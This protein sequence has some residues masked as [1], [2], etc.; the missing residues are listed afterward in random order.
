[1]VS[2]ERIA[3]VVFLLDGQPQLS[4]T[5]PPYSAELRLAELPREQVVRVEGYDA[6]GE[7]VAWDQVVLNQ[8][9]GRFRVLITDP[10]RGARSSGK[11]LARAEV[12]VPEEHRVESVE[13][14]VNDQQGRRP[15]AA[16]LAA[17]NPGAGRGDLAY[18]T[19]TALLDDG[20]RAEDRA[21]PARARQPRRDR[22]GPGR[23][24]SPR[25][26]TPRDIR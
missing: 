20:S 11:V 19:V 25:S 17:G 2:G 18:L 14:R 8:A 9:R 1:M 5:R 16:A 24:L 4:R 21:L 12:V 22:G 7:L 15:R 10:P 3:K 26:S 6:E 13:F 23:A